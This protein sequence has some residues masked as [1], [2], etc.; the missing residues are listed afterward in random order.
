MAGLIKCRQALLLAVLAC[1][2]L[3]LPSQAV[4]VSSDSWEKIQHN[5][6]E[7]LN[8]DEYWRAKPL[9]YQALT[10]AEAFGGDDIR[11]AKTLDE[12]GRYYTI[13]GRFS[14][15]EPFLEEALAIKEQAWGMDSQE[16]IPA[17]GSM[18]RF[19]LNYGTKSKA[20]PL[21][22][23]LLTLVTGKINDPS[24]KGKNKVH[25]KKGQSLEA[26][27][28]V[29][30]LGTH[31][32]AIDWAIT[33]DDVGNL[34]RIQGNYDLSFKLF[35]AA[36]DV[37]ST[38]LGKE[39]LSLANSYD[40]FGTLYVSKNKP[41]LAEA[42]LKDS[43]EMAQKILDP[44]DWQVNSRLEKLAKCLTKE[45]KY[46]E[47]ESLYLSAQKSWTNDPKTADS[48]IRAIFN[49]GCL[50]SDEKNYAAAAIE[51]RR[52]LAIAEKVD[53]PDSIN[54]VPYMQRYAYALYHLGHK[55]DTDNLRAHAGA[56][57]GNAN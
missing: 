21:T 13:R 16:I 15:A 38:I 42:Y 29:A 27:A 37:K 9:L 4:S 19:Y 3:N 48:H 57:V 25:Y 54:L 52:A 11:L 43:L 22:N 28:G 26:W 39:H 46:K 30:V 33:C 18:I 47:A 12:L 50:Y 20:D 45:G 49:L 23:Q 51:F 56:I 36:L 1:S 35:K 40:S 41:E 8:A 5:A 44:D 24:F 31:N 53:G 2:C 7:A 17:M 6:T 10:K 34:Y 14:D 55:Q 32:P